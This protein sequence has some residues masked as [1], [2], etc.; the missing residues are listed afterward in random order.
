MNDDPVFLRAV[1]AYETH[2][3]LALD[4]NQPA[5]MRRAHEAERDRALGVILEV[6]D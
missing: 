4:L 5:D 3:Q 2:R 1:E 6:L